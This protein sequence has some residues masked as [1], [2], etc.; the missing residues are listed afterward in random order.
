MPKK[1]SL[2]IGYDVEDQTQCK[3]FLNTLSRVHN[4]LQT[5]CTVFALGT[6]VEALPDVFAQLA[7]NPLVDIGQHT[8]SHV[9]LKTVVVEEEGKTEVIA[10][11][12]PSVIEEETLRAAAIIEN[13]CGQPCTGLS[14][15]WGYYRGLMDRPDLLTVLQ[16]CGIRYL[17]SYGRNERDWQ[18]VSCDLQPFWYSAQGYPDILEVFLHGWQDVYLRSRLGWD[19]VD[20]FVDY[21]FQDLNYASQNNLAF[22]WGCSDWS[23]LRKDPELEII[24]RVIGHARELG[25]EILS[26]G[27]YYTRQEAARLKAA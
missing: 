5:P 23:A 19:D 7:D 3:Q 25:M 17:R 4:D 11:A 2:L 21:L 22:S 15:P 14:G 20:R 13:V 8:W 10:S 1:G 27:N 26:C 6:C 9:L 16:R 12:S 24:R 18:P